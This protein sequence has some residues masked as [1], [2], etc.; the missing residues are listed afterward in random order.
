MYLKN[1]PIITDEKIIFKKLIKKFELNSNKFLFFRKINNI[2]EL[3]HEEIDVAIG[4]IIKP[5]SL[6][7]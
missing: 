1:I 7:K 3:N 2:I 5:I 6:K 4:I